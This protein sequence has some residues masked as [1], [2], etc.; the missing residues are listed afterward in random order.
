MASADNLDDRLERLSA[1]VDAWTRAFF[2]R[3]RPTAERFAGLLSYPLGWVDPE[4]RPLDPPAPAGKRL[5]PALCLLVCEA[6]GGDHRA[7]LAPAAAIEL[8]HNFSLVHDDIQ[9]ESPL[10]RGRPTVWV[11]WQTSQAINVGDSLF[12]LAQL[13]LLDDGEQPADLL[14]S[15]ARRLNQTCLRLV[16]GQY[17]DLELQEAGSASLKAYQTMIG[18]KTAALLECA[19]WLGARFGGADDGRAERFAAFGRQLGLAYQFQDDLLGIWGDPALTGKSAD[20][21]LRSRKQALPAVL[22]LQASGPLAERFRDL[23]L[24][25]GEMSSEQARVAAEQLDDLGVREQAGR[26]VDEGYARAAEALQ[27]ALGELSH[28]PLS[29][30]L[31]RF[32]DRAA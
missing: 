5:R 13:A 15:A 20:S 30:L 11:R 25:P 31:Q 26:M 22:A 16:E 28:S 27:G 1:E 24:A 10:R 2:Q 32:K 17:L 18:G 29:D 9:D 19:A 8:V 12:A 21:D 3:H 14:V 7:A 6:V 23:F 4:L